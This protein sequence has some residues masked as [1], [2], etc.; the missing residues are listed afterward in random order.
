MEELIRFLNKKYPVIMNF[1]NNNTLSIF[2]IIMFIV[3]ILTC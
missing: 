3:F 1:L 2:L